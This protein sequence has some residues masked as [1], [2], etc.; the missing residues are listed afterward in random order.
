IHNLL[1][2]DDVLDGFD[3]KYKVLPPLRRSADCEALKEGLQDGT[4]DMVT[5]DH[6]PLDI[7]HKK[8]EFDFALNGTIGLESAFGALHNA[9]TLKKTINLLTQGR[10]IFGLSTYNISEGE[11][12]NL[13]L[14][15]PT[16]NY[17]F[18]DQHILSKSKNSIF[19]EYGLKG[20]VY[21]TISNNQLSINHE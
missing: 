2:T 6:N 12:A 9:V 4:I 13:T 7:E 17:V 8:V 3:T 14:F 11:T 1:L 19:K 18:N 20:R 21:G 16:P 15:D 10:S 5:S